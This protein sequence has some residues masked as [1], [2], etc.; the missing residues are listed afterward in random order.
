MVC[1]VTVIFLSGYPLSVLGND[2][3]EAGVRDSFFNLSVRSSMPP[4]ISFPPELDTSVIKILFHKKNSL[5]VPLTEFL[6]RYSIGPMRSTYVYLLYPHISTG[7]L[8]L[9][10][11]FKHAHILL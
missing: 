8:P 9:I 5:T 10:G 6:K 7:L 2:G 3:G 1:P 11:L 4:S